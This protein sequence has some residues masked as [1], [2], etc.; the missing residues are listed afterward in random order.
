MCTA[1]RHSLAPN[2]YISISALDQSSW[3][4]LRAYTLAAN[5][6]RASEN[7]RE[8]DLRESEATAEGTGIPGLRMPLR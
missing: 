4:T 5:R 6:S 8:R 3:L 7:R 1:A 2:I